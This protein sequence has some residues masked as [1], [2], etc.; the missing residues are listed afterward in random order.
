MR[1]L[2][3]LAWRV[4]MIKIEATT[5]PRAIQVTASRPIFRFNATSAP[6]GTCRSARAS[7][8]SRRGGLLSVHHSAVLDDASRSTYRLGLGTK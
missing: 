1:G 5:S 2:V 4:V 8:Y 7:R 6:S 3:A